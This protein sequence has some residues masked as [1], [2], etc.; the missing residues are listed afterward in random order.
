MVESSP[1][2]SIREYWNVN[3]WADALMELPAAKPRTDG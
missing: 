2:L 3:R 1:Y